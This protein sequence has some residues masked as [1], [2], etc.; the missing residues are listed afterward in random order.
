MRAKA[1][2][3][4]PLV[5]IERPGQE[6]LTTHQA[7][8]EE[9]FSAGLGR[10]V[11]L[12]RVSD[13][14]VQSEGYWPDYDWLDQP[15]AIFEF[16]LPQGTF[17]DGMPV[18][19]L[20]TATLAALATAFPESRFDVARFRPNLVLDTPELSG[21]AEER[22]IGGRLS[23]GQAVFNIER[24]CPRC[25]MTTLSQGDLP[26]DPAVLRAAV[27]QNAGNVGVYATVA[28]A[29]M[30]RRGDTAKLI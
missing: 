23:V 3:R 1:P 22:W 6:P 17:F 11:R 24:P 4:S 8:V 19:L 21:F 29:G 16:T 9:Q 30:I 18:L 26:K 13:E 7:N 14:K 10:P 20:T 25:V 2:I 12:A 28:K 27:Q 5:R 15:D